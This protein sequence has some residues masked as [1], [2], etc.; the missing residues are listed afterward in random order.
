MYNVK[1]NTKEKMDVQVI[2]KESVSISIWGGKN[3][4]KDH[5]YATLSYEGVC[6]LIEVLLKVREDMEEGNTDFY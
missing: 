5:G 4:K 6:S 1:I 3:L 2:S